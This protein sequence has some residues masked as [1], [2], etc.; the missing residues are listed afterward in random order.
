MKILALNA[1]SFIR[2]KLHPA[3]S[4]RV[5]FVTCGHQNCSCSLGRRHGPY[6]YTRIWVGR[7]KYVDRYVPIEG[8]SN[9]LNNYKIIGDSILFEVETTDEISVELRRFPL[10]VVTDE[11]NAGNRK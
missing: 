10:F 11:I 6:Y 4:L 2:E 9:N 5:K 7:K 8:I 3:S 1:S